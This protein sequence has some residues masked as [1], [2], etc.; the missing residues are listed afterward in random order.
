MTDHTVPLLVT[1]RPGRRGP[2]IEGDPRPAPGHPVDLDL[3]TIRVPTPELVRL[4]DQ[5]TADAPAVD[6][7]G[8]TTRV[9]AYVVAGLRS[10]RGRRAA[11]DTSG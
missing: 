3:T 7:I 6:V 10:A 4:V 5:V 1:I 2:R 9:R 8:G 11:T